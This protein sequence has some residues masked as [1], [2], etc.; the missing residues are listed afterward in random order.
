MR[1]STPF[2]GVEWESYMTTKTEPCPHCSADAPFSGKVVD[3]YRQLQATPDPDER[4]EL[5]LKM[6]QSFADDYDP[7]DEQFAENFHGAVDGYH[8]AF[9]VYN[10]QALKLGRI[11]TQVL[12]EHFSHEERLKP[13]ETQAQPN[14]EAN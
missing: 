7:A 8:Q 11:L 4:G 13:I 1:G 14:H 3:I 2:N 12:N 6:A 5:L 9:L 10:Q